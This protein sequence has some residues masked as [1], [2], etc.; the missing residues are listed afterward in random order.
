MAIN[1]VVICRG[2]YS[3]CNISPVYLSSNSTSGMETSSTTSSA[4]CSSI[5]SPMGSSV[6]HRVNL[7]TAVVIDRNGVMHN[8]PNFDISR[9]Q[10]AAMWALGVGLG[11]ATGPRHVRTMTQY[12]CDFNWHVG[13]GFCIWAP[14]YEVEQPINHL[15]T[16][17]FKPEAPIRGGVVVTCRGSKICN[18]TMEDLV[19]LFIIRTKGGPWISSPLPITHNSQPIKTTDSLG[20]TDMVCAMN[21]AELAG[22]TSQKRR[23][24]YPPGSM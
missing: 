5:R 11:S 21:L 6:E 23:P 18:V 24:N 10:D 1:T 17:L 19:I 16:L 14:D 22:P 7:V 8:L 4:H 2:T 20:Y 13:D 15:A 3:T 12:R 9:P